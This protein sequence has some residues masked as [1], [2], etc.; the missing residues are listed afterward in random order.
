MRKI[1]RDPLQ[2][3]S[4]N[5]AVQCDAGKLEHGGRV[6]DYMGLQRVRAAAQPYSHVCWV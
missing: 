5:G 2:S 3:R 4:N 1:W 6:L